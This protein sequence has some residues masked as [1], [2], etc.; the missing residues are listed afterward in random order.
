MRVFRLLPFPDSPVLLGQKAV[1]ASSLAA[2]IGL[3][4]S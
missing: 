2:E 1:L 3:V 4:A